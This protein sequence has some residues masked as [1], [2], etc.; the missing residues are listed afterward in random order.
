MGWSV[1]AACYQSLRLL[2][3]ALRVFLAA[4]RVL[5]A[6]G[7]VAPARPPPLRFAEMGDQPPLDG[8]GRWPRAA[9]PTTIVIVSVVVALASVSGLLYL[10]FRQTT[11]PGPVLRD[12]VQRV[13][14]GDCA[15]SYDL[16]HPSVGLT[17]GAWC[18]SLAQVAAQ[19]D[20]GYEVE[21][22]VFDPKRGV[23]QLTISSPEGESVWALRREDRDWLVLGAV[24][25]VDFPGPAPAPL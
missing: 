11:G 5:L 12:F 19:V 17:E 25:G 18:S 21:Q 13:E 2:P 8:G 14:D 24:E 16:I 7:P 6:A 10:L 22:M 20:P 9:L 23:A 1:T 4:R 3:T 15:G